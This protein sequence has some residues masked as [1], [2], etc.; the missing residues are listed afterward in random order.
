MAG[1]TANTNDFQASTLLRV[2]A[3]HAD[4]GLSVFHDG[5]EHAFGDQL[6]LLGLGKLMGNPM[7]E[8]NTTLVQAVAGPVAVGDKRSNGSSD[9]TR[10]RNGNQGTHPATLLVLIANKLKV[11]TFDPAA[12]ALGKESTECTNHYST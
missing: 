3:K 12:F 5:I 11:S 6:C 8:A 2:E 1:Q 9:Q 7:T 10:N 4:R